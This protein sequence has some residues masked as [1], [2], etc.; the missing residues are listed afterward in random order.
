MS[1]EEAEGHADLEGG[2]WK[3]Y[4]G[5]LDPTPPEVPY[6][7]ANGFL[8]HIYDAETEESIGYIAKADADDQAFLA[9]EI[10]RAAC[11]QPVFPATPFALRVQDSSNTVDQVIYITKPDSDKQPHQTGW[12]ALYP[13]ESYDP[14]GFSEDNPRDDEYNVWW[15]SGSK[16][17]AKWKT[18]TGNLVPLQ[19]Y[20]G[21]QEPDP[22]GSETS[23]YAT[24]D[25]RSTL[26][27]LPTIGP[28]IIFKVE[29][30]PER[31]T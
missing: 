13:Y 30:P 5:P 20:L 6:D 8:V 2:R 25:Y 27:K 16:L 11:C 19:F 23:L 1:I 24:F 21:T 12:V 4:D 10:S 17:I 26:A 14:Q 31:S 22:D 3:T 18:E 28:Q 29:S 7:C 15:R 9:T